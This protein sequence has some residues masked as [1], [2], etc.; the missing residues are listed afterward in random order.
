MF[1]ELLQT[2]YNIFL[3]LMQHEKQQLTQREQFSEILKRLRPD[4]TNEDRKAAFNELGLK[5]TT[6]SNYLNGKVCALDTAV[7][8][9]QFFKKRIS[10]RFD[11]VN[12]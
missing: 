4:V 9:I 2:I 12:Q 8:I 6:I 5:A 10:E 3:L 11:A 1:V 7:K